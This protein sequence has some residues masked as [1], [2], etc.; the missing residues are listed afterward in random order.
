MLS[1]DIED[2]ESSRK[3][4]GSSPRLDF[5]LH[6][7]QIAVE[8]KWVHESTTRKKLGIEIADDTMRYR[9]HPDVQGTLFVIYDPGGHLDNPN[10]FE[11][12]M[13]NT[14]REFP[15]RLVVVR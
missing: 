7:R 10:G 15:T 1:D 5:V 9:R 8:A 3:V 12:D 2:E 6:D 13:R 4:L 14:G 11:N